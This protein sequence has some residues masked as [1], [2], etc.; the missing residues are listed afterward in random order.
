MKV[1]SVLRSCFAAFGALLI[2]AP[3]ATLA[4]DYPDP[5]RPIRLIV[6]FPPGGGADTL[7]RVIA[8]RLGEEL[9]GTVII[10]NR[11]GAG[12]NIGIDHVVKSAP[13]GYT[14]TIATPGPFTISPHL[15]PVPFDPA[16]DLVPISLMVTMPDVLVHSPAHV[17]TDVKDLIAK[18]KVSNMSYASG[19]N[20]T[21]G[22]IAGEL[23]NMLVGTK[24]L[25]VPYK[26]TAPRVNDTM[27]GVVTFTFSDPSA[28]A[29]VQAGKL[30]ILAVTTA[31]RSAQFPGVP[32][33]IEAGVPGYELMNWYGL[34]APAGTPADIIAK[35]NRASVKIM[36]EPAIVKSLGAA[37]MDATSSTPLEFTALIANENAR[38]GDLIRKANI[39][40]E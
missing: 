21:L 20:G 32:T 22:H 23:F 37:G 16:K 15:G 38:W 39:K 27:A 28:K 10:E 17:F 6:G 35:L 1:A 9:K 11:P 36:A 8:Q 13:D 19:G 12:G 34:M 25:H 40:R 33:M 31:K 2:L 18:A 3:G 4:A 5:K 26:G 30:K 14:L 7:A 29:M 24:V